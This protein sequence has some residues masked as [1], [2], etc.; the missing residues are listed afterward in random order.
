MA[1]DN[2]NVDLSGLINYVPFEGLGSNGL[3]KFDGLYTGLVT[4]IIPGKSGTGNPKWTIAQVVQ[5]EDEKGQNL[6]STVL[7]G[8]VDSKGEPLIRQLGAFMT[9]IG[10]TLDQIKKFASDNASKPPD[11]KTLASLFVGKTVHI[12]C[13]AE[14]YEGKMSTKVQNYVSPQAY[15]DAKAANAHRKPRRADATFSG[16]STTTTSMSLNVG[17]PAMSNG[18]PKTDAAAKLASLGLPI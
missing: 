1:D 11:V 14:P 9:S 12:Q 15:V 10:M 2:Y 18:A 17:G 16:P 4:K 8:G 6:V 7:I 3:L 5:D 13:E